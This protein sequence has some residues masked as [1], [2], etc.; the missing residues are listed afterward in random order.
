MGSRAP[1]WWREVGRTKDER[2]PEGSWGQAGRQEGQA[3]G[4][5]RH[6]SSLHDNVTVAKARYCSAG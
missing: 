6:N 3:G 5:G 2:R 4:A 1:K